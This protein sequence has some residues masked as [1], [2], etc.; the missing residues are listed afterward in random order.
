VLG[1]IVRSLLRPSLE[2]GH[3]AGLL[4]GSGIDMYFLEAVRS[5][6]VPGTSALMVLSSTANLDDVRPAI[7]RGLARGDV[8]LVH[9]W[10][11]A[12]ALEILRRAAE[13]LGTRT[14]PRS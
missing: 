14:M 2:L 13:E 9:V 10:L 8:S 12:S 6:L 5:A 3:L 4:Q 11:T 7:E 1:T